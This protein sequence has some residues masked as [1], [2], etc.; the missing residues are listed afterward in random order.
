MNLDKL[1]RKV[2]KNFENAE[3]TETTKFTIGGETYDVRSMT[4]K[5]KTAFVYSM[6]AKQTTTAG[7][8]AKMMIKP[9]YDCFGL[10][11]LA[12]KAKDAGYINKYYDIVEMLF[13]PEEI[14]EISAYLFTIN[15]ITE[16]IIEDEIDDIKKQ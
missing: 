8:I 15:K 6:Q 16:E 1:L 14:L 12:V 4:R 5:E 3:N 13:E 9:I 10:K 11:D 7:E 2:E